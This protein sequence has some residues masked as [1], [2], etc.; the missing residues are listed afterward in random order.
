MD[1]FLNP[2]FQGELPGA[3]ARGESRYPRCGDVLRLALRLEQGRVA[4]ARFTARG[5]GAVVAAGSAG[6]GLVIGRP[7][8]EARRL[9]AFDLDRALGGVPPPK[10]HCLLLFLEALCGALGPRP[11]DSRPRPERQGGHTP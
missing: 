5:C 6:L 9:T 2:R 10:R 11:D 1:H 8:E 4:E 3:D 7:V